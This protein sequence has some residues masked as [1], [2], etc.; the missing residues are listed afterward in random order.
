MQD[1]K[2]WQIRSISL[3]SDDSID[4][5]VFAKPEAGKRNG[6]TLYRQRMHHHAMQFGI[7]LY[8]GSIARRSRNRLRLVISDC[9]TTL[10]A[11]ERSSGCRSGEY[12]VCQCRTRPW[13]PS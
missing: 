10:E 12:S 1:T 5:G 6:E 2:R 11:R 3:S 9:K 8:N 13:T 7:H 4:I